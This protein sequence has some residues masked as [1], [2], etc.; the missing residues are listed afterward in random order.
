MKELIKRAVTGLYSS[1]RMEKRIVFESNPDLADNAWPVFKYLLDEGFDSEYE[2]CWIVSRP[3]KYADAFKGRRVSFQAYDPAD[4]ASRLRAAKLYLSSECVVFCNKTVWQPREGQLSL[5]LGHGSPIKTCRGIYT[6]GSFCNRWTYTSDNLKP[7]MEQ[8]LG[9]R[10]DQGVLLGFP[11]ND[12]LLEPHGA[13]DKIIDRRGRKVIFWLPTFRKHRLQAETSYDLPGTG[14]PL[15]GEENSIARLCAK[16]DEAGVMIVLK[17]H[18]AQDMSAIHAAGSDSFAVISDAD[19]ADADVRLYEALADADALM[20]DYSSVYCDYLVTGK[21]IALTLDD[22]EQYSSSRGF[23]YD[24]LKSVLKGRYLNCED[25]LL[26][27]AGELSDGSDPCAGERAKANE[28]FNRW[29]D[30]STRRTAEYIKNFL[31]EQ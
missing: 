3:E 8:E 6:P 11:R 13:L 30:G 31:K 4:K 14:L 18:P 28:F 20:T 1:G 23:V 5:F 22:A 29:Q 10:D 2:L 12:A 25:D 7:I 21:P 9:L 24:D 27:F 15:L 16:L 17:P 26:N 19:L